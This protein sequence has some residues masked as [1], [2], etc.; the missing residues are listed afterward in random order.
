VFLSQLDQPGGY[1]RDTVRL[2]NPVPPQPNALYYVAADW[3]RA[4]DYQPDSLVNDRVGA[5]VRQHNL[6][7]EQAGFYRSTGVPDKAEARFS[8]TLYPVADGWL[9]FTLVPDGTPVA[10]VELRGEVATTAGVETCHATADANGQLVVRF[11]LKGG[12]SNRISAQIEGGPA[13]D[14]ANDQTKF[15]FLVRQ[16]RSGRMV[17]P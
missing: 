16:V 8:L 5:L 15:P 1:L 11:P 14:P 3:A 12:T 17:T 6:V 13:V 10:R 9:E 7:T 4:F 2:A